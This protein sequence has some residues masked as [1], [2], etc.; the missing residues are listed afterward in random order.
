MKGKTVYVLKA[1]SPCS[2]CS[3]K[4]EIY[5]T[6][7]EAEDQLDLMKYN[8]FNGIGSTDALEWEWDI[9]NPSV[10]ETIIN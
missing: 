8:H 7:E 1:T 9:M 10:I 2:S 4:H 5:D 3:G 6:K